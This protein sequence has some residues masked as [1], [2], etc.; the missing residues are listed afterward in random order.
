VRCPQWAGES[1][2]TY[3]KSKATE[4][5]TKIRNTRGGRPEIILMGA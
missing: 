2:N 1:A 4:V 5:L 3:E